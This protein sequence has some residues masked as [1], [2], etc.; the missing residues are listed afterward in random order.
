[1]AVSDRPRFLFEPGRVRV[2]ARGIGGIKQGSGPGRGGKPGRGHGQGALADFGQV[3]SAFGAISAARGQVVPSPPHVAGLTLIGTT[4]ASGSSAT[5]D[6]TGISGAFTDLVIA[7]KLRDAS[8]GGA[9][10]GLTFN[11]DTGANY[12]WDNAVFGSTTSPGQIGAAAANIRF[13]Q[14][15]PSTV[16]AGAH[17]Y[18][19]L[20]I[21]DYAQT[22]AM[23]TVLISAGGLYGTA[24]AFHGM[25]IGTGTWTN[26]AN[27]I[28][29][30]TLTGIAN[31]A[32]SSY[33]RI[34]GRS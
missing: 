15:L 9:N 11:G 12:W 1:M 14:S 17:V 10:V 29:Q 30:L 25:T 5:I 31:F 13:V 2:G 28:T 27:A 3:V 20:V 22:G 23:R 6:V 19:E 34:Y 32:S 8:G 16:T 18:G 4:F 33:V 26:T 21:F 24:S 7:F